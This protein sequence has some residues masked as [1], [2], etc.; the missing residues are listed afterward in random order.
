VSGRLEPGQRLPS[1]RDLAR[2]FDLSRGTA[3]TAFEM[4]LAEGYLESEIGSGTQVSRALPGGHEPGLET[5]GR[6][7]APA[8][9]LSAAARR[10]TP[11]RPHGSASDRAFRANQ[12]ALDLF[13]T[14]D[15]GRVAARTLRSASPSL[16]AGGDPLGHRSLRSAI[17]EY[18]TVSR[19]VAC[20]A[21]RVAVVSG[22]QE[23]LAVIA[24]VLL[25][26]GD[27]VCV[28]DPGYAG[29]ARVMHA[30][31]ARVRSVPIDDDGARVP[32]PRVRARL[33]YLTPA[34]QFPLA[35]S[36]PMARRLEWLAW[37]RASGAVLLEDDYDSEFRYAG[38][39]VSALQGLDRDGVVVFAGSFSKVLCPSLRVGYLVLPGDLVDPVAAM[40]S[41]LT[42]HTSLLNQAVLAR[43]M[44]EGH[45]AR[46][47]R[48][49]RDVYAERHQALVDGSRRW[50]G[51]QL[52]VRAVNA[53]LQTVGLLAA[54]LDGIDV[55]HRAAAHD[56]EV[57]PLARHA[58]SPLDRDG[59][60]I[61]F[62]A[63]PPAEIARGL[64]MLARVLGR[65]PRRRD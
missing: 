6:A 60:Q 54:E 32:P 59:L 13:P 19:G 43:F 11:F 49:M 20:D 45:F 36:M 42:R 61:G 37:A 3:V 38:H 1:T 10:V 35:I 14:A 51:G 16:L 33:A 24:M 63:V 17:A 18:L 50:L 21:N 34:H 62:A 44:T 27:T 31:G 58:R 53:G 57:V 15:W 65:R 9:R 48:R 56:V 26:P 52:E 40:L 22:M 4:L 2:Q 41:V 64:Q 47:L 5:D 7:R 39:P 25:D 23:A 46:H 30:L 28:E 55:A 29:A 12:P 8:R